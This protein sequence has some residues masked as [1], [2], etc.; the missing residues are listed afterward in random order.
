M[1]YHSAPNCF[2]KAFGNTG[3][4]LGE[5][6]TEHQTGRFDACVK[7]KIGYYKNDPFDQEISQKVEDYIG[8]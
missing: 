3:L 6:P 5:I 1:H 7:V 2:Q 8:I 4:E